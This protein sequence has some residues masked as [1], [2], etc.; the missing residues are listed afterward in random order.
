MAND[1]INMQGSSHPKQLRNTEKNQRSARKRSGNL[2]SRH[3]RKKSGGRGVVGI[4][5]QNNEDEGLDTSTSRIDTDSDFQLG[6]SKDIDKSQYFL[7]QLADNRNYEQ[8]HE[9]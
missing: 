4:Y 1:L 3:M 2:G 5:R 6:N 8:Q 7:E 9:D